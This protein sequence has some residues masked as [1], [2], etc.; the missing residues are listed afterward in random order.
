MA[1]PLHPLQAAITRSE[2]AVPLRAHTPEMRADAHKQ[3]GC[4]PAV[5]RPASQRYGDGQRKQRVDA[6]GL[7]D[8]AF[9]RAQDEGP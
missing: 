2:S 8:H 4:T 6:G 7:T 3:Q 5:V 1:E 9:I